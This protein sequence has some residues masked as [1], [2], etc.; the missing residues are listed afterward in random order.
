MVIA[1]MCDITCVN[2]L[3][4][5]DVAGF[6]V[7]KPILEFQYSVPVICLEKVVERDYCCRCINSYKLNASAIGVSLSIV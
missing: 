2:V 4:F 6:E 3:I 7:M 1:F 5:I